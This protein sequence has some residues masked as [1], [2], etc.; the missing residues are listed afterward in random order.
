MSSSRKFSLDS[1]Y[2]KDSERS[3][4]ESK[5]KICNRNK[6]KHKTNDSDRTAGRW[7]SEEHEKFVQGKESLQFHIKI[8]LVFKIFLIR[9]VDTIFVSFKF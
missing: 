8:L 9:Q 2:R 1:D 4:G 6:I 3:V 5:R 7:K